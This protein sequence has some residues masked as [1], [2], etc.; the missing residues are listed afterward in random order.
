MEV[1]LR[2][3]EQDQ[4]FPFSHRIRM[5]IVDRSG[6]VFDKGKCIAFPK[7]E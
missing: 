1:I 2:G 6:V 7:A 3:I 4:Q 5:L